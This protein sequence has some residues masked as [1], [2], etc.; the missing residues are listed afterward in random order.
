MIPDVVC[1]RDMLKNILIIITLTLAALIHWPA[2][3]SAQQPQG[4]CTRIKYSQPDASLQSYRLDRVEGQAVF[5]AP[6]QKWEVGSVNGL[7]V[8]LFNRKNGEL[9]AGVKTDDRGQ[10]EFINIARGEYVLIA[11]AGDSLRVSIPV[12]LTPAGKA[13]KPRRLLLH[14]REKEDER[15]SYV[16]LVTNLALRKEL[17][18]R[19][20]QDQNVR[21]EMIKGDAIHPDKAIV[22]RMDEIDARNTARMKSIIKEYGWPGP[23][24]VGWD[25][26]EAAFILVQHAD[27]ASHKE[28]LPLMQKEFE[29]GNLSGPNYALFIDRARV[30]DGRPQ[31]YGSRAKPFDQWEAGEPALYP[32]EDE[33]NVDKRRAEVGLSSLAEYREF[34]KRLYH[35]QSK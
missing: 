18:S 29:A 4:E 28:L 32:I 26:A 9:V 1:G 24:L 33:A 6:S 21:N 16:T 13:D 11:F 20:E 34:I 14:L 23:G 15:K 17:L 30:D 35:P 5:A 7:C 3:A 27:H 25:G 8:A 31:V 2:D 12:R 22:A 10:F 19:V